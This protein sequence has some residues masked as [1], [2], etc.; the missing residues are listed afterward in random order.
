MD[1][2]IIL[3]DNGNQVTKKTVLDSNG[4]PTIKLVPY[5]GHDNTQVHESLGHQLLRSTVGQLPAIG[6]TAGGALGAA[7]GMG[8]GSVPL[9]IGGA[10]MGASV[11][12]SARQL[13]AHWFPELANAP[14]SNTDALLENVKQTALGGLTEA[15]SP[16]INNVLSAI[17]PVIRRSAARGLRAVMDP[18][19]THAEG[20]ALRASE[21]ILG[22]GGYVS[23]GRASLEGKAESKITELGPKIERM[24]S[25]I[26][27]Y[28][29]QDIQLKPIYDTLDKYEQSVKMPIIPSTTGGTPPVARLT[30]QPKLDSIAAIR[31][32]LQSQQLVNPYTGEL[33]VSRQSLRMIR[34]DLDDLTKASTGNFATQ[35]RA[36]AGAVD[37]IPALKVQAQSHMSNILRDVLNKDAPDIA[38]LNAEFSLWKS[39]KDAMS[40]TSLKAEFPRGQSTWRDLWHA[41]YATWIAAG[42]MAGGAGYHAAGASGAAMAVGGLVA[43]NQLM[44]ST[45]WRT[46]SSSMKNAI[47]DGLAA[48]EYEGVAKLATRL[49]LQG[50]T[51]PEPKTKPQPVGNLSPPPSSIPK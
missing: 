2:K 43:V 6:A 47:A 12:E 16:I 7:G 13:V 21:R 24:E 5:V 50:N 34:Q 40:P 9:A 4:N 33:T 39:V 10:A 14:R 22:Q 3:D 38:R 8:A 32:Q 44:Q 28:G 15:S 29:A 1:D 49:M 41:R 46:V 51:A 11:G 27:G 19:G 36:A 45:L 26:T 20:E 42:G 18:M 25:P 30:A 17:A 31:S 35:A 23:I 48:G 37:P